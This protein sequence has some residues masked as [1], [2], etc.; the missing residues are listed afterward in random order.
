MR[1][2]YGIEQLGAYH[3][4]TRLNYSDWLLALCGYWTHSFICEGF[5]RTRSRS[6]DLQW[7]I[8][9]EH[10]H[11]G[12]KITSGQTISV[13][14][15]KSYVFWGSSHLLCMLWCSWNDL[16]GGGS[17]EG[18]H[19]YGE[20]IVGDWKGGAWAENATDWMSRRFIY[21]I[22]LSFIYEGMNR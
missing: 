13:V 12:S 5:L 2:P 19:F 16:N 6:S 21:G 14:I 3:P 1:A 15:L 17:M 10:S 4:M 20:P 9:L 22:S 18:V 8:M 11:T 7:I